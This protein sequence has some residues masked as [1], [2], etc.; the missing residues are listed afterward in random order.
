MA[1]I[2]N[3]HVPEKL[4]ERD[5]TSLKDIRTVV[6]EGQSLLVTAVLRVF[7]M[8]F[9]DTVRNRSCWK[10]LELMESDHRF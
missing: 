10:K 4:F 3:I 7:L 5:K 8:I 9:Q 2:E 6:T 1:Q